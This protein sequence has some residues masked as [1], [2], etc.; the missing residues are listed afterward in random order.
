MGSYSYIHVAAW[1][2]HLEGLF[3]YYAADIIIDVVVLDPN[4]HENT[5]FN[6]LLINV[7][8]I[9]AT[10]SYILVSDQ[11]PSLVLLTAS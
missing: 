9:K 1:C 2:I 5:S 10:V 3:G 7:S 11:P 8:H 4:Q 6:I